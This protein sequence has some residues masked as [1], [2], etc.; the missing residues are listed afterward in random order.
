MGSWLWEPVLDKYLYHGFLHIFQRS[1][2][3]ESVSVHGDKH[4]MARDR[5]GVLLLAVLK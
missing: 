1:G 3:G 5:F 2:D 4:F